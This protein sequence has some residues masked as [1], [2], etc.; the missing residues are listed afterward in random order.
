[1]ED[2]SRFVW[3]EKAASCSSEVAARAVL[4]WCALFVVP[5]A[6]VS[7]DGTHFTGETMKMVSAR[8]GVAHHFGVANSS[9]TSGTIERMNHEVVRTFRA[10]LS[11]RRRPVSEWPLVVGAVQWALNSAIRE[12]LG[13]TPFQIMTGRPW[14]TAM[15]VLAGAA[16][17]EWT[18]ETLDVSPG[19]M[20]ERVTGW[21]FEQ[22]AMWSRVVERVRAQRQRVREIGNRGQLPAFAV[23]DYV[24]V[25]RM[26]KLG[27]APKLVPT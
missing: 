13:T 7:D 27:S 10:I 3:L 9:W 26:R 8:L 24:L 11:K 5:K 20:E 14:P 22:E 4:N 18:V 1:M 15:S 21:V 12:R 25:A 23:G 17:G 6:F 2:V 19:E 16:A